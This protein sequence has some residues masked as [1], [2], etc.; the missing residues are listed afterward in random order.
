MQAAATQLKEVAQLTQIVHQLHQI[1]HNRIKAH[2]IV[3]HP[4]VPLTK[5]AALLQTAPIA[6]YHQA[7]LK[8]LILIYI[9]PHPLPIMHLLRLPLLQLK[10]QN[11]VLQQLNR[12]PIKMM[13]P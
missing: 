7:K 8:T 1:V 5:A 13:L 3:D 11:Q 4:P 9:H 10:L 2:R 6:L 12:P